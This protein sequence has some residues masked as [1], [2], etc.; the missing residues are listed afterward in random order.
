MY[1]IGFAVVDIS[2][3][4]LRAGPSL[5]LDITSPSR[6]D[7]RSWPMHNLQLD[8]DFHIALAAP[9]S[10]FHTLRDELLPCL[11]IRLDPCLDHAELDLDAFLNL[12]PTLRFGLDDDLCTTRRHQCFHPDVRQIRAIACFQKGLV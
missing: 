3:M 12:F 7:H 10:S 9:I 2:Y 1:Q 6:H 4:I 8:T 11:L 5:A